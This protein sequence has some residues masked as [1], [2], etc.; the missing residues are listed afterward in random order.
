[1]SAKPSRIRVRWLDCVSFVYQVECTVQKPIIIISGSNKKAWV[2]K[3]TGRGE[4][5]ATRRSF[6]GATACVAFF[7]ERPREQDLKEDAISIPYNTKR[8]ME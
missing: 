8:E 4:G 3:Q 2:E 7:V 1:M 6:T 5:V